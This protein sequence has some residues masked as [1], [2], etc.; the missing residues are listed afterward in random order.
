MCRDCGACAAAAN[1]AAFLTVSQLDTD[2]KGPDDLVGRAVASVTPYLERLDE[3]HRISATDADGAISCLLHASL[4]PAGGASQTT[5]S[6][7]HVPMRT[8]P[9]SCDT[10]LVLGVHFHH[11]LVPVDM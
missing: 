4:S 11:D 8:T 5:C 2:I 3:N 10:R 9:A 1:L 6:A 7:W